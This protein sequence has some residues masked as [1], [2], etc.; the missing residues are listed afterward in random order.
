LTL[1]C[2]FVA[3]RGMAAGKSVTEANAAEKRAAAQKYTAAMTAFDKDDLEKA[4]K[5]FQDSYGIV[6]SPN[7]HFMIARTLA[8]LGRNAEA[9]DELNSVIAEAD[10]LGEKYADTVHAAYS[11][12]DE[13]KPRVGLLVVTLDNAPKGTT[14]T[15]GDE[16]FDLARLGKPVPVL[17]G[18]TAVTAAPPGKPKRT[19][20]VRVEAGATASLKLDLATPVPGTPPPEPVNHAPYKVELEAEVV[21]E[22]LAPPAGATRGAGAGVRAS[23]PVT[24][25]GVL[26]AMDNL[27]LATGLDWIGTSTDPHFYVPAQL[28]W[29]I[30]LTDRISLRFEPGA[31]LLF[32]AGTRVTPSLYAGARYRIWKNLYVHGRVGIPVATIGASL[33][34]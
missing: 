5:G 1:A 3:A 15:V 18:E 33:L 4:L 31:A 16:P 2:L 29:N 11:K 24:A 19:G 25:T 10:G 21:G 6:K 30:W 8:R 26:G 14:V 34:L 20:K 12:L 9:Y 32:G 28:Q 23:F 17:P 27:A 13:I 7:S 22:T